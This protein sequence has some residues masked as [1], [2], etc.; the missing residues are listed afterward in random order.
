M[1]SM[2]ANRF[3]SLIIM[4][5]SAA[6]LAGCVGAASDDVDEDE[7]ALVAAAPAPERL[8]GPSRPSAASRATPGP[9]DEEPTPP[10][11]GPHHGPG[12]GFDDDDDETPP[13]P[14]V[15][16]WQHEAYLGR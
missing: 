15:G 10:R 6:S 9:D 2:S 3:F 12:A 8:M 14:H 11:V 4:A 7:A 1:T 16:P 5:L 13:L